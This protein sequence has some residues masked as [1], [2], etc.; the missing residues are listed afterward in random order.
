MRDL[1]QRR[2]ALPSQS[3]GRRARRATSLWD[4]SA[5]W[6]RTTG[7]AWN[8]DR[9]SCPQTCHLFVMLLTRQRT[10]QTEIWTSPSDVKHE[11]WT[12]PSFFIKFVNTGTEHLLRWIRFSLIVCCNLLV[13]VR[14]SFLMILCFLPQQFFEKLCSYIVHTKVSFTRIT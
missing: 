13:Q 1:C 12:V 7:L 2:C 4:S 10:F 11:L 8:G 3:P 5:S 6:A 9:R 14:L